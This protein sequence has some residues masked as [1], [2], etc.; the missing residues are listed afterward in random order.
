MS[1]YRLGFVLKL[2]V[3]VLFLVSA[4]LV[5]TAQI[6]DKRN[7]RQKWKTDLESLKVP[8]KEFTALLGRDVIKPIDGP[9]FWDHGQSKSV[10]FAH[11]PVISV[12]INGEARA[13]P[14]S[15][16]MFH[17]I[18]NDT[19]AGVP[20]SATY[21][22]LCNAAIVFDRRLS[23]GGKDYLLDF[24]TTGMLRNSD[25][26]MWDRQTETWWQQ[27][28]GEGLVGQLNGAL[29]EIVPSMLISYETF[30]KSYP[31]GRVLSTDNGTGYK[32]G[33]N[34]YVNYDSLDNKKPRLFN[35]KVDDRLPAMERVISIRVKDVDKIY[36][37]PV[38][39]TKKVI[40]DVLNDVPVVLFFQLGTV[41]AMDKKMIKNSRDIGAVTVFNAEIEGKQ[42]TFK[43]VAG[44]FED[45][46]THSL[47]N[48]TGKCVKGKLIGKQLQPR[49]HGNHFAFAWFA[50]QPDCQIYK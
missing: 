33:G 28:T 6:V 24:G 8:L 26:V 46:E 20:I 43:A 17:E 49:V 47:W 11:E 38:V 4:S 19:V 50:F 42:L 2:V 14:L 9:G 22:P 48:I 21:C 27:F 1:E 5:L 15:I 34:P 18:V 23:F 41:S 45:S 40:N 10:Y 29:L 39:Q 7:I 16:L 36:P 30:F 35:G 31:G 44:G 25:L 3:M 13:Y 12:V 32:Y 37:L